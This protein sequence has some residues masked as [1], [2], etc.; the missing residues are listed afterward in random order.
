[1]PSQQRSKSSGRESGRA[2][3]TKP[4]GLGKKPNRLDQHFQL[5]DRGG[6]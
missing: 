1:M 3:L 2:A 4:G 6:R 5:L